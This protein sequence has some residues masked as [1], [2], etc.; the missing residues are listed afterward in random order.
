M[1]ALAAA[2]VGLRSTP[3]KKPN[4]LFLLADDH[5]GY[6]LG[7]DGN[8]QAQTPHLDRL[9]AEGVRFTAHH[10]NSPVCTPSRQSLL[11]GQLPHAAGVTLLGTPLSGDAPTLARQF[12]KAGYKTAVFGKMHFNRPGEPGLHGFDAAH[13]EDRIARDWQQQVKAS[14]IAADI[15]TKPAWHPFRDPARVWLNA[16]KLPYARVEDEMRGTF[17]ARQAIDYLRTKAHDPFAL[18]VSFQ[19]PHSPYDFPIE[20]RDR[21]DPNSFSL[22]PVGPEDAGQIPLI[23]RNLTDGEKRG[24]IAAYYTSV[25]FLDRNVGRVLAEL[26]RLGLDR[27]TFVVYTAD[28]GYCLGQHGRFEK[29]CGYEPALRVPLIVRYPP[30]AKRGVISD[31][32]EH[33]DL[34]AT[35]TDLMELDPLPVQHGQS[36]RPYLEGRRNSKRRRYIFSE[37]LENEEAYIKTDEWK[38]VYCTGKRARQD[39]YSTDRPTP[40][41]YRRLYHL[42]S[43]RGEFKDVSASYGKLVDKFQRIMIDRFRETHP[44]AVAEPSGLSSEDLLDFYLRPRDAGPAHEKF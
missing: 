9:A 23:F 42:K 15:R 11:S 14:P 22:P 21:F 27:N 13:T 39:G 20:D 17:I 41:R 3:A 12:Q 37:Y 26:R 18:W 44:E 43:D 25:A 33:V 4:F 24:I 28:H 8:R 36:L 35:V 6:V 7:C 2:P 16:D 10:C 29:H 1:A 19:E 30:L 31:L 38:F 40:G 34:S 5:A 32:T